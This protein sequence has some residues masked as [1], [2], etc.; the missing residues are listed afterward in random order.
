MSLYLTLLFLLLVTEMAILFVLL[1][2]LPHM[3]R[4]RIGYMYNNLKAS[5]QMKTVL[6]VFSILVSSLF[7]DSIKR[8]SRPL[9]LDRNLVTP[10]MLATKA[11]HQRNI[12]ISGFILY[13]GL[14]IPIVMGVIAKLVKYEET[15][16]IHTGVAQRTAENDKIEYEK[17][18]KALMAELKEKRASLVALQ[19]QLDNKN[20]FIDEQLDREIKAKTDTEKKND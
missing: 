7:A 2:P 18:D 13:F 11:Y 5:S 6:V 8:G 10:D 14:C 16:K 20:A 3:V 17:V 4:K 9:P 1:M 15:L 12:Y 19:K